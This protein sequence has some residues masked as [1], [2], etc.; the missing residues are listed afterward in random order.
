MLSHT[1]GCV[2]L[3]SRIPSSFSQGG[4]P[5]EEAPPLG[6]AGVTGSEHKGKGKQA[7]P[8]DLGLQLALAPA[9]GG[10]EPTCAHPLG[11]PF[12]SGPG[13]QSIV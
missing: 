13:L 8:W 9:L 11:P 4:P 5:S 10:A 3:Q 7:S 12:L 1:W 6:T 2:M